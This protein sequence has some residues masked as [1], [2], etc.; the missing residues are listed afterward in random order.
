MFHQEI[1]MASIPS[2]ETPLEPVAS[3]GWES[4]GFTGGSITGLAAVVLS[5]IGLAGVATGHMAA[6]SAIVLG[7]GMLLEGGV[8]AAAMSRFRMRGTTSAVVGGGLSAEAL[9]GIAAIVLGALSLIG[10]V[11]LILTSIAAIVL[12]GGLLMSCGVLSRLNTMKI[13]STRNAT[14]D[15][16]KSTVDTE[17]MSAVDAS[18][19][20][21]AIVLG[22]LALVGIASGTLSL[23]ALLALGG[24][25]MVSGAFANA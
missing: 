15:A 23:V 4:F 13:E 14:Y 10:A 2:S 1:N 24:G 25:T 12:G 16:I 18:V 17:M 5:I 3:R 8:A 22:I 20:V 7:A 9:A 19:G 11:P 6:I 21:A